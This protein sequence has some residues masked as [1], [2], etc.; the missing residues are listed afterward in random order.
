MRSFRDPHLPKSSA[1]VL[2][3]IEEAN[4]KN[5]GRADQGRLYTHAELA[6]EIARTR[7][8]IAALESGNA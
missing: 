7:S 2:L 8:L 4:D 3:S 1:A 6:T 5:R